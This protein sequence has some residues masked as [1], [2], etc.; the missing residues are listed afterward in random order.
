MVLEAS[1]CKLDAPLPSPSTAILTSWF[2]FARIVLC[3]CAH[4]LHHRSFTLIQCCCLWPVHH[5]WVRKKR[6]TSFPF[7]QICQTGVWYSSLLEIFPL[8]LIIC[9]LKPSF[10]RPCRC[11]VSCLFRGRL[12][13]YPM[14]TP[15]LCFADPSLAAS[16]H[17]SAFV[18][19]PPVSLALFCVLTLNE[20]F[21]WQWLC[22]VYVS[23]WCRDRAGPLHAGARGSL[24]C[25]TVLCSGQGKAPLH[26]WIMCYPDT[27]W[28]SLLNIKKYLIIN[29]LRNDLS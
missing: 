20:L 18:I 6:Q 26:C 7:W 21:L 12:L 13:S 8:L 29:Q 1:P 10:T 5:Q 9:C 2:L 4:T 22:F 27:Y 24:W 3:W 25:G 19:F 17:W 28:F 16:P 11:V 14:P 23:A 15:L